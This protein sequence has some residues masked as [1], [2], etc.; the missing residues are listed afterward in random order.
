[1]R[2]VILLC[3]EG[4]RISAVFPGVRNLLPIVKLM[5]MQITAT[6]G[7]A[8]LVLDR[9]E[10]CAQCGQTRAYEPDTCFGVSV[11]WSV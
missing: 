7:V 4:V 2:L 1:M 6:I 11:R 5:A 8:A 9:D 3:L 10:V